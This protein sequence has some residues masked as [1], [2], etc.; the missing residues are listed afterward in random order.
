MTALTLESMGA[1]LDQKFESNLAP[2]KAEL[3]TLTER[4]D[5]TDNR[6]DTLEKK[7]ESGQSSSAFSL[8]NVEIQNLCDICE[9][10]ATGPTREEADAIHGKFVELL[11]VPLQNMVGPVETFGNRFWKVRLH[12]TQPHALEVGLSFKGL[13]QDSALHHKGRELYATVERDPP[14]QIMYSTGGR[15]RA[16]LE[17]KAKATDPGATAACSWRPDWELTVKNTQGVEVK[18]GNIDDEGKVMWDPAAANPHFGLTPEV[19][20][21]ELRAFRDSRGGSAGYSGVHGAS[22]SWNTARGG[23]QP[24]R[25]FARLSGGLLGISSGAYWCG[26]VVGNF[27]YMSVHELDHTEEDGRAD[28]AFEDTSRHVQ[29]IRHRYVGIHLRPFLE[30]MRTYNFL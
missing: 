8:S 15:A 14:Q 24:L 18:F 30:L 3:K 13:V 29:R 23:L 25:R 16:F 10:R 19:L 5:K 12:I 27:I 11:P 6:L 4:A 26:A 2:I 28:R 22:Y 7:M 1:L 21:K 20:Q 9:K 17:R